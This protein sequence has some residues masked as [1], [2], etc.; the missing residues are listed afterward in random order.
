MTFELLLFSLN[1][2]KYCTLYCVKTKHVVLHVSGD[3]FNIRNM[4]IYFY[5]NIIVRTKK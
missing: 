2:H 4:L 1:V 5:I 3:S